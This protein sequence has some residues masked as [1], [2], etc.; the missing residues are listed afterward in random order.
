[1]KTIYALSASIFLLA[2][3]APA[4]QQKTQPKV[5]YREWQKQAEARP[6]DITPLKD[7]LLKAGGKELPDNSILPNLP[8]SIVMFSDKPSVMT[9]RYAYGLAPDW[10]AAFRKWCRS[11][12]GHSR[13]DRKA[14]AANRYAQSQRYTPYFLASSSDNTASCFDN[15]GFD[16]Y[17]AFFQLAEITL[18]QVTT[19][20][21]NAQS[22]YL[23]VQTYKDI[24]SSTNVILEAEGVATQGDLLK[25]KSYSDTRDAAMKS[26]EDASREVRNTLK[27]GDNIVV[28]QSMDRINHP[29]KA[30]VIQVRP[31][32]IQ[33]QLS[34]NLIWVKRTDIF[35]PKIPPLLYCRAQS[36]KDCL[37]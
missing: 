10:E 26:W 9:G 20:T 6:I 17:G 36:H 8:K 16:T 34:Q 22:V 31:E 11:I 27:P 7:A 24:T 37:S 13:K 5:G 15:E 14:D 21:P 12:G 32:L 2:A 3:C 25:L 1:M 29:V 28:V 18:L 4:P 30:L 23:V 33:V 35:S 19:P